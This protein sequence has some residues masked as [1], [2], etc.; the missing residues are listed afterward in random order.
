L[1][2]KDESVPDG[3][4]RWARSSAPDGHWEKLPDLPPQLSHFL[5]AK[6]GVDPASGISAFFSA[7]SRTQFFVYD[8]QLGIN[9]EREGCTSGARPSI[10]IN[11]VSGLKGPL[12]ELAC[13]ETSSFPRQLYYFEYLPG[14]RE[15]RPIKA[16][17]DRLPYGSPLYL[18]EHGW[19][20]WRNEVWRNFETRPEVWRSSPGTKDFRLWPARQNPSQ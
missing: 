10:Y 18:D 7:S 9:L 15:V 4:G 17:P 2:F 16:I 1:Y 6:N 20:V 14:S 12:I 3:Q 8:P 5:E 13:A 11:R 19:E